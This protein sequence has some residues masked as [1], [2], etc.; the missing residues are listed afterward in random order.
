MGC[1]YC[2]YTW[3]KQFID[4]LIN[5]LLKDVR[6]ERPASENSQVIKDAFKYV[7]N[8][9]RRPLQGKLL[10]LA[11]G[12]VIDGIKTSSQL[13]DKIKQLEAITAAG[14]GDLVNITEKDLTDYFDWILPNVCDLC[15]RSEDLRSICD[16]FDMSKTA[17][18]AFFAAWSKQYL[19]SSKE[20]KENARFCE[21]LKVVFED[22]TAE[23][24]EAVGKALCKLSK[25]KIA[26]LNFNVI[27]VFGSDKN[28]VRMW[29]EIRSTAEST[30]PILNN[31]S[32]LFKRKKD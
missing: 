7:Y 10:L 28:A 11:I 16:L 23:R 31:L 12:M 14:K 1:H 5:R 30:N 3:L 18:L 9:Q 26:D 20:D 8:Y 21:F 13:H 24:R 4:K 22:A 27:R 32:N 29:N 6:Y 19:K 25:Q 17:D 2:S 15:D